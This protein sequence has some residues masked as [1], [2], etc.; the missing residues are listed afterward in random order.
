M[1][2]YWTNFAKFGNPNGNEEGSWTSYSSN[3]PKFMVFDVNADQAVCEMTDAPQ[4]K[5]PSP[6]L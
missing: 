6:R 2:D 4:F 1:V 3:A 5:G